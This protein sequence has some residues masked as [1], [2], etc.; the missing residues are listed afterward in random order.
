M[1]LFTGYRSPD[2]DLFVEEKSTMVSSGILDYAFLA[3]SRHPPVRKVY[4]LHNSN[5]V[6]MFS[7]LKSFF[8]CR[9][10]SKTSC[11]KPLR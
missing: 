1:L 10:M 7:R 9:L 6:N 4:C 5:F 8:E 2:C 11:W 3:L